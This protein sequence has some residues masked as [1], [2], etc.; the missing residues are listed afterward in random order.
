[1]AVW[2]RNVKSW[3]PYHDHQKVLWLRYQDMKSDMP[4]SIDR[5]IR[6]LDW[7]VSPE[8]RNRVIEYS[9]FEWMKQHDEK[10]S[11]QGDSG[12][13]LFKPGQF[14]R[15]GQVGK[16]HETMSPD[17]EQ[18]IMYKAR[19]ILEPDCLVFLELDN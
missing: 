17:Q 12:K 14:I 6:F 4:D 8:Q 2:Y 3:W 19:E 5:I 13:P 18:R 10:F 15:Q 7:D 11:S 9:S 1:M 16:H